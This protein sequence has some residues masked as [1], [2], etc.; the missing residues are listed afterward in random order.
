MGDEIGDGTLERHVEINID[1]DLEALM[2]AEILTEN[3]KVIAFRE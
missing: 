3:G 2:G 1:T